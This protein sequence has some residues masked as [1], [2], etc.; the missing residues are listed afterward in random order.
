MRQFVRRKSED[1]DLTDVLASIF[2]DTFNG[3]MQE[4]IKRFIPV[5]TVDDKKETIVDDN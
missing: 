1:M 4:A 5:C 2:W 3:A